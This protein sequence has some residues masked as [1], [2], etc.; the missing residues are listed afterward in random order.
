MDTLIPSVEVFPWNQYFE[1][2]IDTL[3]QQHQI[4]ASLVNKLA[5]ELVLNDGV[6]I[7]SVIGSLVEYAQIH[8][9]FE[10]RIWEEHLPAF[11]HITSHKETHVQFIPSVLDAVE[12]CDGEDSSVKAEA[13]IHFIIQWLIHHILQADGFMAST[14][15][16]LDEGM[17]LELAEQNAD[18]KSQQATTFILSTI[19]TVYKQI[20]S[21]AIATMTEIR[22]KEEV[23]RELVRINKKLEKIILVD[24]LTELYN[25]RHFNSVFEKKLSA[26]KRD[27]TT[28]SVLFIDL[29][30][31][32][33]VN[34]H[35][36]HLVGDQVLVKVSQCL[37]RILKRP[38]DIIFRI[39]GE[40]FVTLTHNDDESGLLDI[41]EKV[42]ASIEGLQIPNIGSDIS[43]Y[44]TASIGALHIKPKSTDT[45]DNIMNLA[46]KRL[47][48]AK[49]AGRNRTVSS[50]NI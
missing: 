48:A 38:N 41:A 42:R 31:F 16:N 15:Q 20:S 21:H 17:S 13:I 29:D 23:Q 35:Y 27:K 37:Q 36:G 4:L 10:E 34:D 19:Y 33:R 11:Y 18:K 32:K 24:P 3:D 7:D 39:G 26:A 5:K 12:K 45:I 49:S 8:F 40:E 46:D 25:R 14:I 22:K 1:I 43:S 50:D 28:L 47:Y 9:E 30:Y 2:G 6:D 44:V